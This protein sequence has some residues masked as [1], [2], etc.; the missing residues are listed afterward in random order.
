MPMSARPTPSAAAR[1]V[2]S[3]IIS[4]SNNVCNNMSMSAKYKR[5]TNTIGVCVMDG[6]TDERVR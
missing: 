4:T 2:S 5:E 6:A 1:S 3:I